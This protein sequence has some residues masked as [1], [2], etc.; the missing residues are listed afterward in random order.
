MYRYFLARLV[1]GALFL[2]GPLSDFS[3]AQA[4]DASAETS[5]AAAPLPQTSQQENLSSPRETLKTFLRAFGKD[6]NLADATA[7]LNLSGMPANVRKIN[8]PTEARRLKEIIDRMW[9]VNY[10]DIP[11]DPSSTKP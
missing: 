1:V 6:G 4:D 3:A 11:N 8:G 9:Y 2:A 10:D 7:A 5:T